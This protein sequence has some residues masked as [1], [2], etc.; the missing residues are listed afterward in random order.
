MDAGAVEG[1]QETK[2][3]NDAQETE[4]EGW[5]DGEGNWVDA[6]MGK[7]KGKWKGKRTGK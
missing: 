2:K 7:N 4:V 6:L 1:E 5:Y 3:E